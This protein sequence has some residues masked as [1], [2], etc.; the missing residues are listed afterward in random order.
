MSNTDLAIISSLQRA[1]MERREAVRTAS[2]TLWRR[3]LGDLP[4]DAVRTHVAQN[5]LASV[6]KQERWSRGQS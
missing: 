5:L 2:D 6:I 1:D 3:D 4:R